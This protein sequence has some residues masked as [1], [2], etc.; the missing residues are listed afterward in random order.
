MTKIEQQLR[1]QKA[2]A[3]TKSEKKAIMRFLSGQIDFMNKCEDDDEAFPFIYSME[4]ALHR[5]KYYTPTYKE[6]FNKQKSDQ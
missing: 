5:L 2:F 6:L 3:F 1:K 4:L